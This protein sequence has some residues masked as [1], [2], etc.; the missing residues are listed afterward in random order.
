[1]RIEANGHVILINPN[2]IIFGEG[3]QVNVGGM[4]AS[5][6]NI[7]PNDFMNGEFTLTSVEGSDGKILNSGIINA[8]TGGSIT[9]VGKQVKNEGLISAKLGAVNLAAGKEA[10]VTFD[11]AGLVGIRVTKEV[12]QQELG[13]DAAVINNGQISSEG[14]RILLSASVSQDIFSRAVNHGGMPQSTSVVTHE[15]GSFTLGGGADVINNG[16][17][18]VSSDVLDAGEVVVVGE[19]VTSTGVISADSVL[20]KAGYVELHATSTALLA[21][22]SISTAISESKSRGGEIKLLGHY[23]GVFDHSQIN[24]SGATGGGEA[25]IGGDF[26]GNNINIRNAYR[27]FVSEDAKVYADAL[28]DGNGGKVIVWADDIARYYGTTYARG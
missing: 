24:V 7:S 13:I 26:R 8:A 1:G 11:S 14:G 2:G 21:D 22:E 23:V 9:L 25:L 5:G 16:N 3:S 4:I 19:N 20:G 18:S 27:T 28:V 12:L 17:L 10:V 6:L 15:D